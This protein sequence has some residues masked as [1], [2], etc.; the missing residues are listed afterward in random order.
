M[1]FGRQY[2]NTSS[3]L[4]SGTSEDHVSIFHGEAA[5]KEM[6]IKR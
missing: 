4:V 3:F 6:P 5:E 1:D 2:N